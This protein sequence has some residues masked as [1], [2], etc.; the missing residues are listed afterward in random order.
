MRKRERGGGGKAAI[1]SKV[2]YEATA[3]HEKWG[4]TRRKTRSPG[5]I[6]EAEKKV[7]EENKRECCALSLSLPF[8]FCREREREKESQKERKSATERE[9]RRQKEREKATEGE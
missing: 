1:H 8:P 2:P 3:K 4:A 5:V 9:K 7:K 6:V